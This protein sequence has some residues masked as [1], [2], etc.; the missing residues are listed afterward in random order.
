MRREKER[1]KG[2]DEGCYVTSTCKALKLRNGTSL[3][4]DNQRY[5]SACRKV[6]RYLIDCMIPQAN[7]DRRNCNPLSVQVELMGCAAGIEGVYLSSLSV[8]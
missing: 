8:S 3:Q 2:N 6:L 4:I 7:Q 1:K 5:L